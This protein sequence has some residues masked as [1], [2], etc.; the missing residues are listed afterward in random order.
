MPLFRL[1][2][3]N[4]DINLIKSR[5]VFFFFQ[6]YFKGVVSETSEPSEAS[7]PHLT[8]PGATVATSPAWVLILCRENVTVSQLLPAPNASHVPSCRP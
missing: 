7:Q 6:N 3:K 1:M 2:M 8:L 4:S 5:K